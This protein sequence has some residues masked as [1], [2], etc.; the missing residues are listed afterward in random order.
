MCLHPQGPCLVASLHSV[1]HYSTN[2][3]TSSGNAPV[4]AVKPFVVANSATSVP[5]CACVCVCYCA[6]SCGLV[7]KCMPIL[8]KP[9]AV[10][11]VLNGS[12]YVHY[13]F[14]SFMHQDGATLVSGP[15]L[16]SIPSLWFLTISLPFGQQFGLCIKSCT[17][18]YLSSCSLAWYHSRMFELRENIQFRLFHCESVTMKFDETLKQESVKF[19]VLRCRVVRSVY[20]YQ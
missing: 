1:S 6:A 12:C 19:R 8:P 5:L 14:G 2:I 17:C 9:C 16:L 10:N 20:Q 15:F 18:K 4:A 7:W 11:I 3:V 13:K